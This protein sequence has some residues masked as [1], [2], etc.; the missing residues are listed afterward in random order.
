VGR[1]PV[2]DGDRPG[3]VWLIRLP[4]PRIQPMKPTT[5]LVIFPP[6][7]ISAA[8]NMVVAHLPGSASRSPRPVPWAAA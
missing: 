7:P 1:I 3:G 4:L 5:S 8:L 6:N 2:D